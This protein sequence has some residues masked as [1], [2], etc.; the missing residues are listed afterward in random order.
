M[1]DLQTRDCNGDIVGPIESSIKVKSCDNRFEKVEVEEDLRFVV[2]GVQEP[3]G[4]EVDTT[5]GLEVLDTRQNSAQLSENKILVGGATPV[6][7]SST[8]GYF[9]LG[10]GT[11]GAA[12][13]QVTIKAQL[14]C[15]NYLK[16]TKTEEERKQAIKDCIIT[17]YRTNVNWKLVTF[18]KE[19][20]ENKITYTLKEDLGSIYDTKSSTAIHRRINTNFPSQCLKPKETKEEKSTNNLVKHNC[21]GS[22]KC[23]VCDTICGGN[24]QTQFYVEGIRSY[25]DIGCRADSTKDKDGITCCCKASST[26]SETTTGPSSSSSILI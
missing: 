16:N 2:C 8:T 17:K 6:G 18:N 4:I 22:E 19:Q 23:S 21:P 20:T 9:L 14:D 24:G 13:Y 5:S 15:S 12:T 10:E 1:Y 3:Y 11:S 25:Q 7:V 26:S